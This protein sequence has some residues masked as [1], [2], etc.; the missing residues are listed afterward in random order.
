[1]IG[2]RASE[3][4]AL[5]IKSLLNELPIRAQALFEEAYLRN[6]SLFEQAQALE[7]ELIEDYV[8]GNLSGRKLQRFERHTPDDG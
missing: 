8:K 2:K 7:E 4:D 5:I 6:G 3:R 1:M